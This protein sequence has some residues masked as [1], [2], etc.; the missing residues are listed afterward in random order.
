LTLADECFFCLCFSEYNIGIAVVK[1]KVNN[2]DIAKVEG[3]AMKI[4]S[5]EASHEAGSDNPI[6]SH[7][8]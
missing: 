6:V 5:E 1:E 7:D 4:K 8:R 2:L 3:K